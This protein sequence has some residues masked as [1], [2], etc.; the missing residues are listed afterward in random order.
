MRFCLGATFGKPFLTSQAYS[1]RVNYMKFARLLVLLLLASS[2]QF[3]SF[4]YLYSM[5]GN[6]T[7]DIDNFFQMLEP[8]GLFFQGGTLYVADASRNAI[9]LLNG[10]QREYVYFGSR[11]DNMLINPMHMAYYGNVFY[12]AGG[13]YSNIVSYAGPG[14]QTEKWAPTG[15]NMKKPSGVALDNNSLY[16]ADTER[17]QVMVYLQKT[18]SFSSVGIDKGTSEGQLSAPSDILL[19]K[20]RFFVSDP[21]K[22]L[23]LVYAKNFTYLYSIGRGLGGVTLSSPHGIDIYNERLYVA[24]YSANRVVEFTLDGYP[25]SILNS[26]TFEGNISYPED[27]ALGDGKLFVTDTF[28]RKIKVFLLNQTAGD[29]AVLAKLAEA[30]R[31]YSNLLSLQSIAKK[32]GVPFNQTSLSFDLATASD[33]YSDSLYSPA[34]SLAQ[35]VIDSANAQYSAMLQSMD[36]KIRQAVQVQ[37]DRMAP[38][39][40]LA[41]GNLSLS[42]VQFDNKVSDINSKISSGAY[43]SAT[44]S[45]LA[46]PAFVDSFI[47]AFNSKATQADIDSAKLSS[48]KIQMQADAVSLRLDALK[49]RSE[50]YGQDL[51]FSNAEHFLSLSRSYFS[52]GNLPSANHSLSLALFDIES[53]EA[54][55]DAKTPA[56][57]AALAN[58]TLLELDFKLSMS[59]PSIVPADLSKEQAMMAQARELAYETPDVAVEIARRASADARAK[60]GNSQALSLVVASFCIITI[61]IAILAVAFYLHVRRGKKPHFGHGD[62]TGHYEGNVKGGL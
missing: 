44:N 9:Y 7:T 54:T 43:N 10:S 17:G 33:Y 41:L 47:S 6:K 13:A 52:E 26:S 57:D 42:V 58:I 4:T 8:T 29:P 14:Y 60:A 23:V 24:D 19:Y 40:T 28:N 16:I 20:D 21:G 22:G 46:L 18:R 38:Y 36:L 15:N 37:Q 49:S 1:S 51:N 61:F 34:D 2:L 59:K 62:D 48:E 53:G 12:I 30:N 39:R 32:L 56:I 35:S 55:L 45:A 3:A 5:N 27:V 11:N 25:L 31:T 50:K